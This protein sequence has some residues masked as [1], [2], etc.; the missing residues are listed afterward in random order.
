[1]IAYDDLIVVC[2]FNIMLCNC[3]FYVCAYID[4]ILCS[5]TQRA[6]GRARAWIAT[7]H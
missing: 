1:M 5:G 7:G 2:M 4:R 3:L 6:R